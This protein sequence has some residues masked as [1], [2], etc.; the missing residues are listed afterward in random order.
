MNAAQYRAHTD[1]GGIARLLSRLIPAGERDAILGDLLE[2]AAYRRLEG[3]RLQWW[4]LG[5][6]GAIAAGLSI[7]RVRAWFVI[8]PVRELV[9]GFAV[10]GRG[11]LRGTHPFAAVMRALIF[12]GSLA[13]I[14]LGVELL[15]ASLLSASGL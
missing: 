14:V 11:V 7:A 9:S 4:L 10:D 3:A 13:T 12:C 8:V 5:E 1:I 2:D 6:C 15:V